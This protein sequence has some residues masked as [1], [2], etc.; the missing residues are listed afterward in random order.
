MDMDNF[1]KTLTDASSYVTRA[2]QVSDD[3]QVKELSHTLE[4]VQLGIV[5]A[6]C[7]EMRWCLVRRCGCSLLG[8]V[9][10]HC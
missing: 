6:L 3:N 4:I 10:A 1:K 9:D 8:N 7:L 2:V 5:V